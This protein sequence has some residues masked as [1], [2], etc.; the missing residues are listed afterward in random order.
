MFVIH[1]RCGLYK[2]RRGGG[3][4]ETLLPDFTFS[5]FLSNDGFWV[6]KSSLRGWR[7]LALEQLDEQDGDADQSNGKINGNTWNKGSVRKLCVHGCEL[8]QTIVNTHF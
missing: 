2:E 7:Q 6:G 5:L 1:F 3:P 4:S 8:C